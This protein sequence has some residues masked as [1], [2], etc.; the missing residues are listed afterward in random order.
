MSTYHTAKKSDM[1]SFAAVVLASLSIFTRCIYRV[2]ELSDG[3]SGPLANDE[4]TFLILEGPMIMIAMLA[5]SIFHPGHVFHGDWKA[6]Q[7]KWRPK[8][9]S[10]RHNTSFAS[11][12]ISPEKLVVEPEKVHVPV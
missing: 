1:F 10:K 12:E 4:I 7:F 11:A 9:A 3:F 5:L 2:V 6:S 8:Q